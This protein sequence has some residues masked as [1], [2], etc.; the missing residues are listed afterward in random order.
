MASD[1][2]D[3]VP[4][5]FSE[6]IK[7]VQLDSH[8]YEANLDEDFSIGAVPN[9]GYAASC[10]LAAASAHLS[11][12]RQADLLT[13]HFE[14]PSRTSTGAAVVVIEDVKLGQ[15]ISILHL[16]LWQGGL[17][18]RA[19]WVT[20]SV[21]RRS[22]L[23]YVNFANMRTFTGMTMPTGYWETPAAELPSPMPDFQALKTEGRDKG[24]R[25][26]KT[27]R[28]SAQIQRSLQRWQFYLPRNGPL[29]P[30][31][32]DMWIRLASG[33][34]ITQGVLAYVV[35]SFPMDMNTFFASTEMRK[36]FY[37]APRNPETSTKENHSED[38][39]RAGVWLP[40]VVMNLEVKK[41]L[42]EDGVEWL[43]VCATSKQIQDGKFDL[44]LVVRDG[45][46]ELVALSSH[47]A[48][49]LEMG[50]NTVKRKPSTESVL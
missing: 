13:A 36:L 45:E 2:P 39:Q 46:G 31:V 40:T 43:A 18:S 32:C 37:N 41:A 27:P 19:P 47:V 14:F 12:R 15:Q 6:A 5:L 21:S 1:A 20:P 22:I 26:S 42:P 34:R 30:G 9:G 29:T 33:E 25:L 16:T 17:L 10:M 4:A 28:S 48:L 11:S 23:G 49:I 8:T 7:V 44:D 50:R 38:K 24:W 35:D 3:R